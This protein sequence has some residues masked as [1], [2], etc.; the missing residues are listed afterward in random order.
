[1][2]VRTHVYTQMGAASTLSVKNEHRGKP[3]FPAL[4]W[5]HENKAESVKSEE[6]LDK[7]EASNSK[8]KIEN[9]RESE[10]VEIQ[11]SPKNISQAEIFKILPNDTG[12]IFSILASLDGARY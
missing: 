1:M 4:C 8:D 9:C 7:D 6:S 5:R 3:G 10:I 2:C 12:S 11:K